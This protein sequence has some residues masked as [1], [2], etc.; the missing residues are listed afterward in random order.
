MPPVVAGG[1]MMV[2]NATEFDIA[3]MRLETRFKQLRELAVGS[4][5]DQP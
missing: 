5:G 2:D 4:N 3:K 1:V